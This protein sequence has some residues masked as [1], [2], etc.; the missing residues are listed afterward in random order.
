MFELGS[1]AG[2]LSRVPP[3][4]IPFA[5]VEALAPVTTRVSVLESVRWGLLHSLT[6]EQQRTHSSAA[7]ASL[8]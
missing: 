7:V 1:Q 2:H 8:P 3:P 6:G 4:V 5:C